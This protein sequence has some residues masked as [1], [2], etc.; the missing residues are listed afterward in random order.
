[1]SET[2]S[3]PIVNVTEKISSRI[4]LLEQESRKMRVYHQ[5]FTVTTIL[6]GVAAPAAVTYAA[7]P[8][9]E[10]WWKLISIA[11]TAFAT[12]SATIRTVLRFNERYSNSALTAIALEELVADLQAKRHEVLTQVKPEFVE[13]KLF[14][15]AAW[16]QKQLF[17]IT[18]S[19]VEK[20]VSAI[21]KDQI[22][23]SSPPRVDPTQKVDPTL[24]P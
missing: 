4:D 12:G 17:S 18:K 13:Q 14:E 5:V 1:M 9:F 6:L 15:N 3:D 10:F 20:D 7:P 22:E 2:S 19:Y 11:V 21:T 8:S 23:L 24:K 16:G